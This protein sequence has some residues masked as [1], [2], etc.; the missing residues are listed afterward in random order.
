MRQT[1]ETLIFEQ[2]IHVEKKE[3][4]WMITGKTTH[5]QRVAYTFEAEQK[6][7]FGRVKIK[8][9]SLKR[10]SGVCTDVHLFLEEVVKNNISGGQINEFIQELLET[11]SKDHQSKQVQPEH[12]PKS[13]LHYEAL[14]SHMVD[15]HPY[16]P[17]YKSRIGFSLCDNAK[18]G[19]EH[20]RPISVYWIAVDTELLHIALAEQTN[21]EKI[22]TEHLGKEEKDRYLKVLNEKGNRNKYYT[23]LPVHPWQWVHRIQS[24][25]AQQLADRDMIVLGR[26][27]ETYRAQQSIRSLA[28][29][30]NEKATYI[31]CPLSITNTSSSRIL[32]SHTVWNAPMI[33][34]WLQTLID[35]DSFLQQK[36]FSLLREVMG[37]S[38]KYDHLTPIQYESAY[39]TLGAIY[40]ENVSTYLDE[41]E[42]AWPLNAITHVQKN[43]VPL[44]QFAC[45]RHGVEPWREA[46]IEAVAVP[47]VHLLC[48]HGIA[49]EAHAQNIILVLED[50][51]P[52]RIIVKD[53][54]DGVRY[55]PEKLLD[56]QR[57]PSLHPEPENHRR[58]NRYSFIEAKTPDEVRD[59][60]YDAFFFICMTEIAFVFECFGLS[61]KSFW[62]KC[63]QVIRNYQRN[64]PE[65]KQRYEQFD[66]FAEEILIEEMTKRRILGDSEWHFLKVTNPLR[67]AEGS[68][69]ERKPS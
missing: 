26:S 25:F 65:Y 23:L 10:E 21:V 8:R 12:I 29:R 67:K 6:W 59:Y 53:L 1:L 44:I 16:H 20:D 52:K 15:G 4:E 46:L 11:L 55:V 68:Q 35:Q 28:H 5:D 32:A 30:T 64:H 54:H 31:K 13:D 61:E 63:A 41:G 69:D 18:Y 7:S 34:D 48:V 62:R 56:S 3:S 43:G 17:S 57:M 33:S 38:L 58:V 42:E 49:L 66:L 51:W 45:Q 37:V 50:Q 24:V 36:R 2:I 39:G 19:P 47:L 9:H 14:E 40:R 60:L 27:E 22:L